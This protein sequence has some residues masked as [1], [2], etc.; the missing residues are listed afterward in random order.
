VKSGVAS[1]TAESMALF[2]AL[3]TVRPTD[4]RLFDDRFATF[5]VRPAFAFAWRSS[6][7]EIMGRPQQTRFST[8]TTS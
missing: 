2:R 3:E 8:K 6:P 1:R 7:F 5:F 4:D